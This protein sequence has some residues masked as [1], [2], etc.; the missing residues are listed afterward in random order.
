[1][2]Y[3]S[4]VLGFLSSF[5]CVG[6]CGPIA[7]A[8]PVHQFSFREKWIKVF[9]YHL[10]RIATYA[11]FGG[12]FGILGRGLF[13]SGF[14]K[15][16]SIL[17]GIVMI[18]MAFYPKFLGKSLPLPRCF[19]K[20]LEPIKKL[21]AK[22]FKYRS[23]KALFIMGFLNGFLP[24]GTVYMALT[25]A[26]AMETIFKSMLY[27]AFYGLGTIPLMTLLIQSKSLFSVFIRDRIQRL[28]PVFFVVLGILL[29]V[30][31]LSLKIPYISPSNIQLQVQ[32]SLK[33]CQLEVM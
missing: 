8:L 26:L 6:M 22:Q 13:L 28:L 7:L 4:F 24:C 5:H 30:R 15:R 17:L 9:L 1:M 18:I 11:I 10:G 14:Q 29:I 16:L 31:S 33:G 3:T 25:G 20:C 12:V 2:L 19:E 32:D 23:H 21:M 27:M